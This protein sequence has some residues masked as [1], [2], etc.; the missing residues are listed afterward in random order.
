MI[1]VLDIAS[2]VTPITGDIIP[3][4]AFPK[5]G[6]VVATDIVAGYVGWYGAVVEVASVALACVVGRHHD[7]VTR[8]VAGLAGHD[9]VE[10]GGHQTAS[11]GEAVA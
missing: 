3:I 11:V 6:D 10:V 8:L 4:I 5:G 2:G 7:E 1:S 9:V